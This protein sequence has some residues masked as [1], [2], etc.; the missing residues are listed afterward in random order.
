MISRFD[1][2]LSPFLRNPLNEWNFNGHI[3][4]VTIVAPEQTGKSMSWV[5]GL[6]YSYIFNPGL[7][8][9]VYPSD[10][11]GIKIN[12]EKLEPLMRKIPRLKAELDM[13][14]SQKKDCYHFSNLKS[15]FAGAGSRITSQSA[16]IR[17]AD[18]TDDFQDH[19]GKIT[20][21]HDIRKRARSFSDS[22]FYKVCTPTETS[23]NIWKEFLNSSQGY[24]HLRCQNCKQL[25]IRSADVHNL[26]WELKEDV[27][28]E[29]SLRLICPDCKHEHAESQKKEMNISGGYV[30]KVPALIGTHSGYQWGALASQWQSLSW[31]NI[32]KAQMNAGKSA[33]YIDQIYLD[34]SIRGLPFHKRGASDAGYHKLKSHIY[35]GAFPYDKFEGVFYAGDTQDDRIYYI[36]AGIDKDAN[37]YI[38]EANE[39]IAIES[40]RAKIKQKYNGCAF[41]AGIQDEGGHRHYEIRNFVESF[42]GGFYTWKGADSRYSK[43]VELS[44]DRLNHLRGNVKIFE[45]ETL[46]YLHAQE[47]KENNY[48]YF[49]D[50]LNQDFYKH[51][52]SVHPDNTKKNGDE[53][54]NWTKSGKRWDYF[55][56]LKMLYALIEFCKLNYPQNLWRHGQGEWLR[57][58][59]QA[60][61][62]QDKAETP[63]NVKRNV[64]TANFKATNWRQ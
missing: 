39:E 52:M 51:L 15:Y 50:D 47:K 60:T 59:R 6:L 12:K 49:R 48:L 16:R 29:E 32:A 4:E 56:C 63:V 35:P 14:R 17:I 21:L 46:Y 33:A 62:V 37:I 1:L 64:R 40:I 19:E 5:I 20:S 38:C 10:D 36:I 31:I 43:R 23:G 55:D 45:I 57:Q 58:K 44:K 61:Q 18:E 25:S 8:L 34:N 30:H 9:V 26:Q 13:P 7:S 22:M 28:D 24:W 41:T 2:S 3:R 27:I 53:F 42:G 11:L 54:A